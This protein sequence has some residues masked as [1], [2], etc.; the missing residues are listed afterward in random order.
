MVAILGQFYGIRRVSS[1]NSAVICLTLACA[2]RIPVHAT[3]IIVTNTD[4]NGPGSLR[5]ALN[6]LS[7]NSA[8]IGG[9]VNLGTFHI[10][11]TILNRGDSGVNIYN[12]GGG[13]VRHGKSS[14]LLPRTHDRNYFYSTVGQGRN[15]RSPPPCQR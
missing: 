14:L 6:T 1:I 8:T 4:D 12:N 5:Q 7:D 2:L 9:G 3:T 15:Q 10:R 13:T 11:N